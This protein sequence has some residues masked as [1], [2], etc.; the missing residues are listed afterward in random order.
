[1]AD[2]IFERDGEHVMPTPLARGP[3]DDDACHG[4]APAALLAALID[5]VPSV[6]PM[7]AVRLTYEILRP[8]PLAPLRTDVRTLRDGKRVQVVEADLTAADGTE[9]VRCRA[10]RIRTGDVDV[11]RNAAID[12]PPPQPGPEG[13]PRFAGHETWQPY[14]FWDAIDVRFVEGALGPA[15]P[16]TCWFRVVAPLLDGVEVTPLARVA[17]AADFGNGIGSPV[18][19]GPYLFINPDLNINL[20]RLPRGDWIAMSS[21][22]VAQTSGIGLTTST[23][24]DRDGRIGGATQSLFVDHAQQ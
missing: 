17:A 10:L 13:L 20:H 24:Y 16:A 7:Q 22:S 3:W 15:G 1:M 5:A 23:L 14:G 6:A 2:A 11:P 4:G 12:D 18:P 21:R 19:F 8:V 9:L